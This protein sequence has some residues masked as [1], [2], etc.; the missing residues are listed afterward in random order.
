[1]SNGQRACPVSGEC[2]VVAH[3]RAVSSWC[4][5]THLVT[6]I[7][8]TLSY[9]ARHLVSHVRAD[10]PAELVKPAGVVDRGVLSV[11]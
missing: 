7:E 2:L 9:F 4:D 6:D 8:G 10:Q 1:M 11:V 5:C 3:C